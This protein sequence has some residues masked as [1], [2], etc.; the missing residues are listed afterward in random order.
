MVFPISFAFLVLL[1]HV[2]H[3]EKKD[4]I[5]LMLILTKWEKLLYMWLGSCI[6]PQCF[7][8]KYLK[9]Y[10][11]NNRI[12]ITIDKMD[13]RGSLI[14]GENRFL[15]FN[16]S[17]SALLK[18]KKNNKKERL[19]DRRKYNDFIPDQVDKM[20]KFFI[21]QFNLPFQSTRIFSLG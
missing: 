1:C 20:K 15:C 19:K 9:Q 11:N 4:A 16:I 17:Q 14:L 8:A 3:N 12:Y 21:L 6:F 7:S 10:D 2:G 5:E 18:E 13:S